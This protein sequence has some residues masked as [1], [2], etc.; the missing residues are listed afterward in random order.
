MAN[1]V[2]NEET[3]E[4]V[5][6]LCQVLRTLYLRGRQMRPVVSFSNSLTYYSISGP[7]LGK[8]QFM[9]LRTFIIQ[10]KKV[11]EEDQGQQTRTRAVNTQC[12][13]P[14]N[15]VNPTQPRELIA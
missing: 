2:S 11:F 9:A 7:D 15:P 8:G 14:Y 10:H 13:M 4:H 1:E 12:V 5:V 6:L 3:V